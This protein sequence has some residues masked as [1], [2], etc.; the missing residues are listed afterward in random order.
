MEIR[1]SNSEASP[2]VHEQAFDETFTFRT[3]PTALRE[4]REQCEQLLQSP[5]IH[6]AVVDASQKTSTEL[7][8][9]IERSKSEMVKTCKCSSEEG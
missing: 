2:G 1:T 4:A 7:S 8:Q 9:D 5:V 6:K 3:T